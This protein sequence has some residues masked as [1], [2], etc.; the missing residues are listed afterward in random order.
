MWYN[1]ATMIRKGERHMADLILTLDAGTTGLKCSVFNENGGLVCACTSPYGVSFPAEGFAEQSAEQ[2]YDAAVT[3]VRSMEGQFDPRRVAVIGLS[4]TMNGCLAVDGA[5]RALYP[6]IIHADT[7]AVEELE[8]IRRVL[9]DRAYYGR[10]AN[11]PDVHYTLPKLLWLRRHRPE[12]LRKTA[13]VLNTKDSIYGFLTGNFGYTDFSDASLTGMFLPGSRAWDLELLAELNLDPALLPEIVPSH[14]VSGRLIKKA[15]EA[16]G[17]PQGIPVSMGA[18]DGSCATRGAGVAGPGEAYCT[19]GSSAWLATLSD[20]PAADPEMRLFSFLDMDGRHST[21][22][23]TVQC[24]AAAYDWAARGLFLG[25]DPA[26]D[27]FSALEEAAAA[28]PVGSRGVFFLP[29]LLGERTPWW[30]PDAR[31]ALIGM[32]CSHTRADAVRAVY[33]GI[34]QAL[35]QCG[36]VMEELGLSYETLSLIGG[37][38]KS[39]IWP[40]MFADAFHRPVTVPSE[41]RAA[42]SLGAM[43]AAGVG[44]GIFSS[45]EAAAACVKTAGRYEPDPAAAEVYRRHFAV[46]RRLYGHL[47]TAY[48][49]ISAYQRGA[50][51]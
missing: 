30:D 21:V 23:G 6:N 46:Y 14:D 20:T 32:T 43:A 2:F 45:Y 44:V 40:Q 15:A 18:G 39:S 34:V 19:V 33:E 49:E 10:T 12:I 42:T 16:L 22:C 28:S 27:D 31:G 26:G 7:R 24:A 17:F 3:A 8:E 36:A 25:R 47:R 11:R 29:T 9:D 4:G 51:M 50:G 38:A 1:K 48:G 37:G 41:P 5:G 35:R 13:K